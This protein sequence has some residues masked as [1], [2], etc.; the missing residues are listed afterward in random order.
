MSEVKVIIQDSLGGQEE[1]R[2]PKSSNIGTNA[3]VK[4]IQLA[5]AINPQAQNVSLKSVKA[6]VG[7]AVVVK[8]A[9]NYCESNVGK[10][11]GDTH[12]QTAIN[13]AKDLMGLAG[14]ALINPIAA[15][16]S[17]AFRV[18]TTAADNAWDMKWQSVA[19]Q[20]KLARAGFDSSG[21]AIGY[22]RN[23]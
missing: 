13:N 16:S 9:V 4:E 6:M 11:T 2:K 22:R 5:S 18:G 10:W 20:R 21:E 17:L 12:N 23:K 7:A 19:S 15:L 3:S 8:Q 1:I 14:L